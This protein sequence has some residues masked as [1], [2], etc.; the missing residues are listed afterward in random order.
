METTPAQSTTHDGFVITTDRSMPEYGT[1]SNVLAMLDRTWRPSERLS[2]KSQEVRLDS[3]WVDYPAARIVDLLPSARV[4]FEQ[5]VTVE[6]K[7][8][9][10]SN[11]L[12]R[13]SSTAATW[14]APS[15]TQQQQLPRLDA[16]FSQ[17]KRAPAPAP[18]RAPPRKEPLQKKPR[19]MLSLQEELF[20][21]QGAQAL[22][23][24]VWVRKCQTG[25]RVAAKHNALEHERELTSGEL[26]WLQCDL[27]AFQAS[28]ELGLLPGLLH[29]L[30]ND[31]SEFRA[32]QELEVQPPEL[33]R[34]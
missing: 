29:W 30:D 15:V 16:I 18:K 1:Q 21:A 20:A 10:V 26:H 23:M 31:W 14:P 13:V 27:L 6:G 34:V 28:Q 22:A 8:C 9:F 11:E 2:V 4:E 33:W 24:Q 32:T 25:G 19:R 5:R 3:R 17:R 12:T 7:S